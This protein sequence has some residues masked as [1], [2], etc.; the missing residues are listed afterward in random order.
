[1]NSSRLR[2]LIALGT[3]ACVAPAGIAQAALPSWIHADPAHR[4]ATIDMVA[5][6]NPNN[7]AL[8]FNGYYAGDLTIVI[9]VGWTVK[10][11]FT[12]HDGMLPHSL[13]VT[14]AYAKAKIPPQAGV[15]QV[16]IS[17]AYT[18]DPDSGLAPGQKDSFDF[19]ATDP[20]TYWWFCGVPG[21]GLE[22]MH[23][24][25]RID[26]AATGPAAIIAPGAEKGRP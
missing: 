23:V 6:W 14:K 9:P 3:L 10:V 13:L 11:S 5:G 21:H 4:I 17:K 24:K 16:A 18:D 20:G 15:N 8:N 7:S 1:M 22:G 25:L 19:K 2:A 26:P 12:N